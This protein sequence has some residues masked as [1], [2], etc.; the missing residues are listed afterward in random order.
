[1]IVFLFLNQIVAGIYELV[2]LPQQITGKAVEIT[3][4]RTKKMEIAFKTS[5]IMPW[6]SK[7][8]LS[9]QGESPALHTTK[10]YALF[11]C[12]SKAAKMFRG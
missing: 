6:I 8:T 9:P 4:K 2:E 10:W 12:K 3:L 1:M 7:K 11:S 5:I